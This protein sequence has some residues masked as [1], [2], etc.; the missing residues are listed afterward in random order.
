MCGGGCIEREE[1]YKSMVSPPSSPSA[2]LPLSKFCYFLPLRPAYL[3]SLFLRGRRGGA[4]R[5]ARDNRVQVRE[6][7]A[8]DR[9]DALNAR[10]AREHPERAQPDAVNELD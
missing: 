10:C 5:A 2:S 1:W 9:F 8:P 3:C 6:T 7:F 4:V